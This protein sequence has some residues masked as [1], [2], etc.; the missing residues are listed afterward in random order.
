MFV[1]LFI[2]RAFR[3]SLYEYG[4]REIASLCRACVRINP[5]FVICHFGCA[6]KSY[7][8]AVKRGRVS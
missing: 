5:K 1:E 2:N 4:F 8:L 7:V 6:N 3:I